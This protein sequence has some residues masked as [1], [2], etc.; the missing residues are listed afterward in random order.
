[1]RT[2]SAVIDVKTLEGIIERVKNRGFGEKNIR[3]GSACAVLDFILKEDGE[4]SEIITL[5]TW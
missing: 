5:K 1:M 4:F 3:N 2:V